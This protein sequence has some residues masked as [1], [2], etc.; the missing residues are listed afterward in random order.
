MLLKFGLNKKNVLI[1]GATGFIGQLV[2]NSLIA[3]GHHVT[4]LTR[5]AKKAAWIFDE[6]VVC[7]ENMD[8]LSANYP[9]GIIINLAGARVLGW[10]WTTKRQTILRKSRITLTQ[11]LVDWIAKA[12]HK[13]ELLLSA[14]AIGYYGIQAIGDNA[15]LTEDSPTQNIFMAKLCHD[16]EVAAQSAEQYGVKVVCMRFGMVLGH[17]G[18]LPMLLLPI[19]LFMGGK[20]GSGKQ[21]MSWIHVDDLLRAMAHIWALAENPDTKSLVKPVYNFTAPETLSQLD[22]SKV[23]AKVLHRPCFFPTPDWPVHLILGEQA[24]L[25]LEGQRVVPKNLMAS[26]FKFI[27]GNAESALRNLGE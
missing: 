11:S 22:F 19:K 15:E 23:A 3:N 1:T 6:K 25:L 10:R 4:V 18:P 21:W 5:N 16:W 12:E 2:V 27:Y 17:Q 8:E 13:P 24:D 14:S 7:I 9:L 20:L 26:G